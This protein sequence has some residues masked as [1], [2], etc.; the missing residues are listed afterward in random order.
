MN[1][2][3]ITPILFLLTLCLA[4]FALA[5]TGTDALADPSAL[6][7]PWAALIIAITPIIIA[8]IKNIAPRIPTFIIPVIAPLIGW[9][10]SFL[11]TW[12]AGVEVSWWQGLLLGLTGVGLREVVSN[13][14]KPAKTVEDN[15][16]TPSFGEN[17]TDT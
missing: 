4:P 13:F 16:A 7:S 3:I 14:T 5:T 17:L 15:A 9:L 10:L 8:L 6:G 12:L 1:I 2:R 11:A